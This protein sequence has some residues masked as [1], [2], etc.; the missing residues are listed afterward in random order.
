[1]YRQPVEQNQ[2]SFT[3]DTRRAFNS[4]FNF[5]INYEAGVCITCST[6]LTYSAF[7]GS[8]IFRERC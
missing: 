1:M 7:A 8:L 2:I 5:K 6:L 4:R 3:I